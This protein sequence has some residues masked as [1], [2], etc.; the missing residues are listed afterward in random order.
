MPIKNYCPNCGNELESGD[1][2]F[3]S[4]CGYQLNAP[5]D[6]NEAMYQ[7]NGFFDNLTM[8][9]SFPIIVLSFI[10]TAIFI[11]I[12]SL[13]WGLF[14]SK[15]TISIYTYFILTFIFASFFGGMF[16]GLTGCKDRTYILPNFIIYIGT[17]I[18]I[19]LGGGSLAFTSFWGAL[20]FSS[21][22]FG[23][24]SS[25]NSDVN[26]YANSYYND[27]SGSASDYSSSSRDTVSS[28]ISNIGFNIF[29]LIIGIPIANYIGIEAG[30]YLKEN[31]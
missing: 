12:G 28:F 14:L 24:S 21:S 29:I 7:H 15:Q 17:I 19:L 25:S 22:L 30:Y 23:S 20:S 10:V 8:K 9:T 27:V 26:N 5:N 13:I 16:I 6:S 31:I 11:F 3:C 4:E 1:V 18:A 2:D